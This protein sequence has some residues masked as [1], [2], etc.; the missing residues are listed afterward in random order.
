VPGPR[1]Y[2]GRR[3][4]AVPLWSLR[5]EVAGAGATVRTTARGERGEDG[6]DA[7]GREG[8]Q[9][10]GRPAAQQQR[11]WK[12]GRLVTASRAPDGG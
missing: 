11:F 4:T 7:A 3:A 10:G 8:P 9:E 2:R 12:Y 1:G 6:R 5:L